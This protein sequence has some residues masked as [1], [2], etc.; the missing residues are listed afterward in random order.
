VRKATAGLLP[1]FDDD[2]WAAMAPGGYEGSL[3]DGVEALWYDTWLLVATGRA[4][5]SA[6]GEGA[7]ANIYA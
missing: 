3:A 1:L 5:G 6:L 2:A 7:P 4:D